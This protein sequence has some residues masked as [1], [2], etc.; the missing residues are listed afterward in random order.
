MKIKMESIIVILEKP[1][2]MEVIER[3]EKEGFLLCFFDEKFF[4]VCS[5]FL[6]AICFG[7]TKKEALQEYNSL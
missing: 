3:N 4:V 2:Q 5:E 1:E 7:A 6:L